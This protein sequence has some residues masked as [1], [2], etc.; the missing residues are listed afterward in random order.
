LLK[1]YLPKQ[2]KLGRKPLDRR[3]QEKELKSNCGRQRVNI[4]GAVDVTTL[5]TVTDF[6][7]SVNAPSTIRLFGKLEAKHPP[8]KEIHVILDN[9]MYYRSKILEEWLKTTRIKLHFLPSYSPNLNLIERL[10]KFFKKKILSNK[11]YECIYS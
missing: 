4:N 9:A 11:Y 6:T 5:E 2:K 3:G 10:W 8:V 7:D 1:K